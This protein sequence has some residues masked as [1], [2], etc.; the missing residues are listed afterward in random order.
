MDRLSAVRSHIRQRLWQRDN[1]HIIEQ[2]LNYEYI[3]D[4][5][6]NQDIFLIQALSAVTEP[7]ALIT[8]FLDRFQ[9]KN[10]LFQITQ[11]EDEDLGIEHD[12]LRFILSL[13][14][15]R[16]YC[17]MTDEEICRTYIVHELLAFS[18]KTTYSRLRSAVPKKYHDK[19]DIESII[20]DLGVYHK[21]KSCFTPTQEAWKYLNIYHPAYT[22]R[23]LQAVEECY[24]QRFKHS[25]LPLNM[26]QP[27]VKSMYGLYKLVHSQAMHRIVFVILYRTMDQLKQ[28]KPFADRHLTMALHTILFALQ[29]LD[30]A[31]KPTG[32]KVTQDRK[33]KG[34][35]DIELPG[36]NLIENM[37]HVIKVNND[38]ES[39]LSMLV[40]L[41]EK[42]EVK[43]QQ[44]FL[45]EILSKISLL[46]KESAEIIRVVQSTLKPAE[47]ED[48]ERKRKLENAKAYQQ[49]VMEEMLRMQQ[50]FDESH[51]LDE[52]EEMEDEE[53]EKTEQKKV[54]E[55]TCVFCHSAK[56]PKGY[57][58][59]GKISHLSKTSSLHVVSER[60]YMEFKDQLSGK[61]PKQVT[62]KDIKLPKQP[63][64]RVP[65]DIG[66]YD[67]LCG[68]INYR[69][70]VQLHNCS[71][72]CHFD[73]YHSYV[74]SLLHRQT[75]KGSHIIRL[76]KNECL[77]P[78]C[79]RLAN[80][81][82]PIIP[83]NHSDIY[84]KA[85][86]QKKIP[87]CTKTPNNIFDVFKPI[88]NAEINE[89]KKQKEKEEFSL[90]TTLEAFFERIANV[91]A[92]TNFV[93]EVDP[94]VPYTMLAYNI[95]AHETAQRNEDTSLYS[96][97][98]GD[99]KRLQIFMRALDMYRNLDPAKRGAKHLKMLVQ[100]LLGKPSDA[101]WGKF[102][103]QQKVVQP[104]QQS[105]DDFEMIDF[106]EE[107]GEAEHGEEEQGEEDHEAEVL[108]DFIFTDLPP[109]LQQAIQ[110]VLQERALQ[111]RQQQQSQ[112]QSQGQQ[113]GSSTQTTQSPRRETLK[114]EKEKDKDGWLPLLSQDLYS[115][116]VKFVM[117][118]PE[119]L[120]SGD[121]FNFTLR[122]FYLAHLI[123][124]HM[125]MNY[126]YR[127]NTSCSLSKTLDTMLKQF[128]SQN[129]K[130]L[131]TIRFSDFKIADEAKF[132]MSLSLTFL[133]RTALFASLCYGATVP[134]I[135][136]DQDAVTQFENLTKFLRLPSLKEAMES[137]DDPKSNEYKIVTQ[138][139][140]Q[141][142]VTLSKNG[143]WV[144]NLIPRFAMP[145]PYKFIPLPK[146]YQD[147]FLV[148]HDSK[149]PKCAKKIQLLCL[150]C[151]EKTHIGSCAGSQV[152]AATKVRIFY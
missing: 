141:L 119:I 102:P 47:Q 82:C 147:L 1:M 36:S 58:A 11:P 145:L 49:K 136:K 43:E 29:S 139:M 132:I 116:F 5:A 65:L 84:A 85:A 28:K 124:C 144:N 56:S 128:S 73:C 115:L 31:P 25:S 23:E 108:E 53:I 12:A 100:I 34:V 62:A 70:S 93:T 140:Q 113:Q 138:W 60:N 76:D 55:E 42:S 126:R 66:Y 86:A 150:L 68:D 101:Y 41:S 118:R 26:P 20:D 13:F 7:E 146:R 10:Q 95:A 2:T 81:L 30:E 48:E 44:E 15:D 112:Q 27:P 8:T 75:F 17:G 142:Q 9:H 103:A 72:V 16:V 4:Y 125:A 63:D 152:G 83:Q 130:E 123:Q 111:R 149:C 21:H 6:L 40:A 120:E 99:T 35:Y 92:G 110:D 39:I 94:M 131:S 80:S 137:I 96:L 91:K 50:K 46:D 78:V 127:K 104:Q 14:T 64:S 89:P 54:E 106:E 22:S 3:A 45:S 87:E 67:E 52:E 33:V 71:H 38:R 105:D 61:Q 32:K 74:M 19:V 88:L 135:T 18:D 134:T 114:Q 97:S 107:E 57:R 129:E 37:K 133:R 24:K 151:G 90:E 77:C 121:E 79:G 143:A 109:V 51:F 122:L 98:N 69:D 117:L 148:L 59:I